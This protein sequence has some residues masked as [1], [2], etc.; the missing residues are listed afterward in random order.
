M[1][2]KHYE[3]YL[4]VDGNFEDSTVEEIISKYSNFLTK[5]NAEIVNIERIG[6]KRLAYPIQKKQNGYYICIEFKVAAS[7]IAELDRIMRI[8]E[9]LMR[10]L[11]VSLDSKTIAEREDYFEKRAIRLEKLQNDAKILEQNENNNEDANI[12]KTV[13]SS[14]NSQSESS[15]TVSVVEEKI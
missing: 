8:D 6:R 11:T 12:Q 5:N 15:D 9:N 7:F 4:I 1:A 13:A 10:Y 14:Q 3:T 2:N